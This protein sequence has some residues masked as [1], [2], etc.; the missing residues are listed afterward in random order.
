MAGRKQKDTKGRG[1]EI[2][3]SR[4]FPQWP[5][6]F[7]QASPPNISF[8]YKLS[9][10]LICWW[11]SCPQ[12]PIISQKPK[13]RVTT[14]IPLL[15]LIFLYL[16]AFLSLG[17]NTWHLQLKR[18][19]D[20]LGLLFLEDS[21]HSWLALRQKWQVESH[22]WQRKT[23]QPIAARKERMRREELGSRI[24]PPVTTSN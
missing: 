19:E 5:T 6:S 18:G 13:D 24:H 3:P 15:V 17:P 11:L 10:R 23:S 8:S 9:S 21:I 4:P 16:S 1:R 2:Y 20:Y 12:D 7:N 14:I 22:A